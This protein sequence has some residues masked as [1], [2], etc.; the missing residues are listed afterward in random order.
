[1]KVFIGQVGGRKPRRIYEKDFF[2]FF[3]FVVSFNRLLLHA[4][5]T[6]QWIYSDDDV[7]YMVYSSIICSLPPLLSHL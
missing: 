6:L 3:G 2:F 7:L 1:M 4:A 5:T